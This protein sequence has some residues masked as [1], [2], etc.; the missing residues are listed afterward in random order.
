[1]FI[2]PKKKAS[3]F[4]RSLKKGV[5]V[6]MMTPMIIIR[7]DNYKLNVF[8][9][10]AVEYLNNLKEKPT[11]SYMIQCVI[12][13]S[14]MIVPKSTVKSLNNHGYIETY[15]NDNMHGIINENIW[16]SYWKVVSEF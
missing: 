4:L 7:K 6:I 3:G 2:L 8:K 5:K 10:K 9:K 11:D 12:C 1:M 15:C 13:G 16:T 14:V